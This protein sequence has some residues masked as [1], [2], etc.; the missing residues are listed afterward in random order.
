MLE[1][2]SFNVRAYIVLST[3]RSRSTVQGRCQRMVTN[4][5]DSLQIAQR[6]KMTLQVWSSFLSGRVQQFWLIASVRPPFY[7]CSQ[8]Q[9]S[10]CVCKLPYAS[11]GGWR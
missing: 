1:F 5:Q 8:R 4:G 2:V 7:S 3:S 6:F 9:L 11:T 10:D